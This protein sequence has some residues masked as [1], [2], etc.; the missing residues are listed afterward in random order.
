MGVLSR[1]DF[2]DPNAMSGMPYSGCK[3]LRSA[4]LE[5]IDV[6][7]RKPEAP[8]MGL[9]GS[10]K[11]LSMM[12]PM[13]QTWRKTRDSVYELGYVLQRPWD[14]PL[15]LRKAHAVCQRTQAAV[16][17]ANV[18]VLFGVCVSTL[19]FNLKTEIPIVYASDT[20]AHLMNTTYPHF[21]NHTA[22][23]RK[24]CDEIEQAAFDRCKVFA[25]ASPCTAESAMS[26]YVIPPERVE[27]VEFGAN[28]VPEDVLID[29]APPTKDNFDLVLIAADPYR[30]RLHH[31]VAIVEELNAMGWN[32]R[33]NYVGPLR[34]DI[35]RHPLV[36]SHGPLRLG[37]PNDRIR[38]QEILRDSHWMILASIAEAF[39]IAPCEA[40]HFGRPSAVSNVGGLPT[41]VQHGRTGVVL[42]TDATPRDYATAILD[43]SADPNRYHA[44]SQAALERATTTLNWSV[45]AKRIRTIFERVLDAQPA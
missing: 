25:P 42:P 9:P 21:V 37:N 7:G 34:R 18:D 26:H 14:Y 45:W 17:Q 11:S 3:A 24:A 5:L 4:G 16:D 12:G 36:R 1:H 38:L 44:L 10:I 19:L 35:A 40:A 29:P 8:P 39:G 22:A 43:Y 30:K 2:E 27:V 23:Y 41:V 28:V 15:M 13:R 6:S 32:A 33:L 20:T 31:T